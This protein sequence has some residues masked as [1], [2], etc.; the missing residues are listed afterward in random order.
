MTLESVSGSD[1]GRD[2]R[3]VEQPLYPADL[4]GH[5]RVRAAVATPIGTGEDEWSP[6]TYG[7]VIALAGSTSSSSTPGAAS[8]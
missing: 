2:L 3:W 8:G 4:D 5:R 7:H 6:E 1:R